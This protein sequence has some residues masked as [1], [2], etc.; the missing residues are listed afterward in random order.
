MNIDISQIGYRWKGIYSEFLNYADNDV[1]YK[2]GGAYVI[3]N[4]APVT[5]ALGQQDATLKGHLLT[6]GVSAG[7]FGNM[8]LHSK[9]AGG[10]EFRFQDTKNGTLAVKLADCYRAGQYYQSN[11]F[12]V[13]HMHD[14]S[15]RSWGRAIGG[16][17]GTGSTG[18]TG[19][20]FPGRVAFPPG[21][22]HITKTVIVWDAAYYIDA[23]GGLW[24]SGQNNQNMAGTGAE[25]KLPTKLNGY[26]DI[27]ADAV[28]VDAAG[29]ADWYISRNVFFLDNQ[30]R[31]YALGGNNQSLLGVAGASATPRIVPFT[32]DTPIAK[33]F[34]GGG[35][36]SGSAL[37]TTEGQLW[38]A[39]HVDTTGYN[40][41]Y[42]HSLWMPWGLDKPV[43][44]VTY[45][46]SDNHALT[47]AQYERG[48]TIL[49]E[50]GDLYGWGHN[51]AQVG[52]GFGIAYSGNAWP[53]GN[54]GTGFP[55][56]MM[57]GVKDAAL[58]T[59]GYGL[60]TV[61]KNDGT[62]WYSGYGSDLGTPNITTFEQYCPDH[63][64]DITMLKMH[65]AQYG[66]L[67]VTLRDDGTVWAAG[68][69]NTGVRGVGTTVQEVPTAPAALDKTVVDFQVTGA[70]YAASANA[71]IV[72][73]TS[74]GQ[75]YASGS[76]SY[77]MTNDDD[78]SD[79]YVP[80]QILF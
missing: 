12:M 61:L 43:K 41:N 49:L 33:M 51:G 74:D 52:H 60:I 28:I 34:C 78:N 9:G 37:I 71:N 70:V 24:H 13:A 73:L 40:P 5:F 77:G 16:Q 48:G 50:N 79:S 58:K 59:G 65:G 8:V 31:V 1:V 26:G 47:D 56:F 45:S 76:G 66:A 36:Y 20:T 7:G 15:L 38:V 27:P 10:V 21:T 2:D 29:G 23:S 46:E 62:V 30:G 25:N 32:I 44:Q 69:N 57:S 55:V 72:Y 64:T 3:R 39:G 4:G 53:D 63:M 6:G 54:A 11:Y 35:T 80:T 18:D 68:R 75:V 17:S 14:G 22:P 42:P 19:R 67:L